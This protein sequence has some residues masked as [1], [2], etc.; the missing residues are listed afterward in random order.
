MAS[1]YAA[2]AQ[3]PALRALQAVRNEVI[4]VRAEQQ[5]QSAAGGCGRKQYA[6]KAISLQMLQL[7]HTFSSRYLAGQ[8]TAFSET[9]LA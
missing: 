9:D 2:Q 7:T 8:V 1:M 5:A 3:A 6:F 4:Q